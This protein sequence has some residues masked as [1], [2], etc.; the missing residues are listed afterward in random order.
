MAISNYLARP[1]VYS[2]VQWDGTNVADVNTVCQ[3]GN[4]TFT[5]DNGGTA[6]TP[7]GGSV[8]VAVG[9]YAVGSSHTTVQFIDSTT[10]AA[11][12]VAGTAWVVAL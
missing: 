8:L 2:A 10:L 11:Q 6:Y 12:F 9:L 7:F 3:L 4:W 1:P 5:A